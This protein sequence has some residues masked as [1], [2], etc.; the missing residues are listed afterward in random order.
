MAAVTTGVSLDTTVVVIPL[1]STTVDGSTSP[2]DEFAAPVYNIIEH[3]IG[4]LGF[5]KYVNSCE[6]IRIGN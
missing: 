5:D 1:C 2:L 6:V 3:Q 4:D